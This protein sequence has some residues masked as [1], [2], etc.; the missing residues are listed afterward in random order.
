MPGV[1]VKDVEPNA[2]IV[3]YAAHLKRSG[4]L[5]VPKWVDLVKTG[6]YKELSPYDPDW[7]YVRVASL[8]RQVYLRKG[9]GVGTLTRFHGGKLRRGNRP[10][11]H[12]HGSGS[13]VR[14][15]LQ[16][17]EKLKLV[18]VNP[19]GGRMITQIGQQELDRIAQQVYAVAH[20]Q[21]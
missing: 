11:H 12:A 2:L 7:F 13:V 20:D 10:N 14:K 1:T 16:A 15:A 17:L 9:L 18:E 19:H 3:A 21:E 4:K 8:A 5:E 6:T